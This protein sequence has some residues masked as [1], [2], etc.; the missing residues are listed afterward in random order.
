MIF[1][2][3][4]YNL[5]LLIALSIVSSFIDSRWKKDTLLG[6]ILQGILFG[7]AAVIGML[8]PFVWEPGLIFDGRSVMISLSGLFFGPLAAGI[9][10]SMTALLRVYQGGSGALTGGWVILASA[11]WGVLFH[12]RR[13]N[14]TQGV[15][16]A[17]L[18]LFG[19]LVHLTMLALMFTLPHGM[20]AEVVKGIGV[21]VITIYPLA[22]VLIGKILSDDEMRRNFVSVLSQN[23]K[24]YKD[25]VE[26]SNSIIL[27]WT[28]QGKINFINRF[29][30]DFFGYAAQELLG[31][32][33][34]DTLLPPDPGGGF[35]LEKL[36]ETISRAPDSPFTHENEN[37]HR[38]GKRVWISW[39]NKATLNEEG[40]ITEVLS[41]GADIS[42]RKRA[43]EA[44]RQS[45]E[46]Y[47][48]I[49][50]T[51]NEG[52][53][54][55]DG[56]YRTTFV[57]QRMADMLGYSPQ[58]MVGRL[59]TDFMFAEDLQE[60]KEQMKVR[61]LGGA[62]QYERR[63]RCKDGSECWTIV[64]ATAL[65]D[66]A[67]AFTGS[68]ALFSDITK[69]KRADVALRQS[70]EKFRSI[71]EQISDVLFLTDATGQ[72]TYL[73][74]ATERILGWKPEEIV[75][76]SFIDFLVEADIPRALEAFTQ[77][78]SHNHTIKNFPVLMK[79][80]NGLH[81]SGELNA[82]TFTS[83]TGVG[84]LGIIRD[85]TERKQIIE[86]MMYSQKMA[87]LGTLAAGVAHEINNPLQA[88]TGTSDSILERMD[89]GEALDVEVLRNKLDLIS[90][91]SWRIAHIVRSLNIYARSNSPENHSYFFNELIRDTLMLI[92]HQ[93]E[94]WSNITISLELGEDLPLFYCDRNNITQ[95][96]I[97]LIMNARD[98]MPAG[99]QITI[100]SAYDAGTDRLILE[101][102]DTGEGIPPE[103]RE[104]I[105]SPFFTTKPVG[106]GTGLGL[107][108][109]HGIVTHYDGEIQVDSIPK[110]GTTFRL[111]FP[112]R[113]G[114]KDEQVQEERHGRYL[115]NP[116]A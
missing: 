91:N 82:S 62:G 2:D 52:F 92:E 44:L 38:N 36:V 109:V 51:A 28:P 43:E 37:M 26:N 77:T 110:Q 18:L 55:M 107:S 50:E 14:R 87:D 104:K 48:S 96:L 5:T 11:A 76:H 84:T 89:K 20:G 24:K 61:R 56:E 75:G 64:S 81:L 3:L 108:I 88:I 101:V 105:F 98:A 1:I 79:S 59:V 57:N 49:I 10:C 111:L 8:R 58:E 29:G 68:F 100:R 85:V 65:Q 4:M 112:P 106:S 17:Y 32:S 42:A 41:V 103:I 15:N 27:R 33:L 99:G 73:S 80:K 21:P 86:K 16:S 34:V 93:L 115:E 63:F 7:G 95:V 25:L 12:F 39:T 74:P 102:R 53:W 13:D 6:V 45:E 22:T 70:E 35:N 71:A 30:A 116:P 60:H 90:R 19:L 94:K 23:E 31:K 114:E 66:A 54:A 9:A 67:K 40:K 83:D 69:R 97:N 78:L 47:R 72:V 46:R 113:S